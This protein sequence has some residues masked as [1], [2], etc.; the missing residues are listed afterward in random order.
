MEFAEESTR[1]CAAIVSAKARS[2]KMRF[3]PVCASSK[4][5]FTAI[6]WVFAPPVVTICR[7]CAWLTPSRG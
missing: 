3:T 1:P 6:T 7:R 2:A 4:L 5:P